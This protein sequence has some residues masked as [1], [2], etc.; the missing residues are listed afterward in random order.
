MEGIMPK[1]EIKF[2]GLRIAAE[3]VG[4][5]WAAVIVLLAVLLLSRF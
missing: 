3:G 2:I 1:L 4:A 5:M